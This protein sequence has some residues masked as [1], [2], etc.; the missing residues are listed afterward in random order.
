[1]SCS[2]VAP[3]RLFTAGPDLGLEGLETGLA[4]SDPQFGRSLRARACARSG[5]R[6]QS[7]GRGE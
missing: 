1:M 3:A 2:E 6:S 5:L 7:L 4:R